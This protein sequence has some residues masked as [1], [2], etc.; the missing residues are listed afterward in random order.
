MSLTPFWICDVGEFEMTAK[1]GI[2]IVCTAMLVIVSGCI[3]YHAETSLVTVS[4]KNYVVTKRFG[5]EI[6]T[7]EISNVTYAVNVNGVDV[8]CNG[9]DCANVVR[10]ELDELDRATRP[11]ISGDPAHGAGAD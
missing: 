4:G 11:A 8:P 2:L 3:R 5:K 9:N 1:F 10:S 7:G 6:N